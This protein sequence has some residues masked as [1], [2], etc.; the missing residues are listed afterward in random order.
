MVS[1][2]FV[3]VAWDTDGELKGHVS[4][5]RDGDDGAKA[6]LLFKNSYR[7]TDP[8]PPPVTPPY[9]PDKPADPEAGGPAGRDHS[10]PSADTLGRDAG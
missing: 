5:R 1:K 10:H 3:M 9:V 2:V 6:E 4:V 7:S 8:L